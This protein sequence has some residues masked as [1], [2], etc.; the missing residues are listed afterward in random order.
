[1]SAMTPRRYLGVDAGGTSTRSALIDARGRVLARGTAGGANHHTTDPA[2]V[3]A[4]VRE[5]IRAALGA[6]HHE[7]T[8]AA[9]DDSCRVA[10]VGIG[11]SGLEAP[12]DEADA[13]AIVG[14][15]VDAPV[16]VL[17]SDVV[18]AHL[19]AFTG[20]PGVLVAAGTGS[21]VLGVDADGH[22]VRVGGWGHRY[23]DEGSA[24]W[25]ATEGIRAALQGADGR[26]PATALWEALLEH[27]GL[28]ADPAKSFKATAHALTA[29]LYHP[30]RHL[31]DVATFAQRL[32]AASIAGD[33]VATTVLRRAGVEL[34]RQVA[35]AVRRLAPPADVAVAGTGGVWEQAATVREG[36][37]EALAQLLADVDVR[38]V[39]AA[40]D[41]AVG[42]AYMAVLADGQALP[43]GA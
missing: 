26:G 23:G 5:A 7:P 42:A 33:A 10:A 15:S 18:A 12:G 32:H 3:R 21:I 41:P 9:P 17:D 20:R 34:A 43:E 1:M 4:S 31:N 36:C 25:I 16:M 30:S 11:W 14:D 2:A 6:R 8:A 13:R 24:A 22:R 28:V 40:A 35:A 27:A 37:R 29:W 19:G 39:P 38:W